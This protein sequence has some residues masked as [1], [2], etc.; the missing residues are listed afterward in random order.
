[1]IWIFLCTTAGRV[2]C[3]GM[4]FV[5]PRGEGSGT[6]AP[7]VSIGLEPRCGVCRVKV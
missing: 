4:A 5:V 1:M 7:R 3:L 2:S 6:L